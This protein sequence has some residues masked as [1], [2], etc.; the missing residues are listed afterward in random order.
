MTLK[1]VARYIDLRTR[2]EHKGT[3]VPEADSARR[4]VAD[5]EAEHPGIAIK[6]A[7]VERVMATDMPFGAAANA[8][9]RPRGDTPSGV[10]A[11]FMAGVLKGAA[12]QVADGVVNDLTG[13]KR[14]D[15]LHP[16]EVAIRTLPCAPD[17]VCV[18]IRMRAVD[19]RRASVRGEL[20]DAIEY[21]LKQA[22]ASRA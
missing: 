11:A 19:L 3:P 12:E 10:L 18:E 6:A 21:E 14:Q 7:A 5:L 16:R 20:L 17:Q 15:P 9:A 1:D 2:A 13:A 4:M 22:A 8:G